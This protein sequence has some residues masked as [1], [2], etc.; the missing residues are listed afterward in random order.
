MTSVYWSGSVTCCD[1]CQSK[2]GTVMYDAKTYRGWGN[3]CHNCFTNLGCKL[4]TGLGQKYSRRLVDGVKRWLKV[5][6]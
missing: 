4:G 2:F 5:A 3:L 1:N 6:G